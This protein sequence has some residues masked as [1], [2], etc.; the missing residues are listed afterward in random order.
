MLE[1]D[2]TSRIPDFEAATQEGPFTTLEVPAIFGHLED[3]PQPTQIRFDTP[4]GALQITSCELHP[5]TDHESIVGVHQVTLTAHSEREQR[6]F[7]VR[8]SYSE[9]LEPYFKPPNVPYV[10]AL[11]SANAGEASPIWK[12][13]TPEELL[14]LIEFASSTYRLHEASS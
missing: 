7:I 13:C 3:I 4:Q 1:Q 5:P 10:S 11:S 2:T 12:P 6:D 9:T 14:Y 8:W